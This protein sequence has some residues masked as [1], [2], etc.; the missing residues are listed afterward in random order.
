MPDSLAI[1]ST[2]RSLV[3][4]YEGA[5]RDI[6]TAFGLI[7]AAEE[8]LNAAFVMDGSGGL[9]VHDSQGYRGARF[10]RPDDALAFLKKDTWRLLVERLDIRRAL[11]VKAA[12]QLDE[13]LERGEM[14]DIT[15]EGVAAFLQGYMD[16]LPSLL[17]DAVKEVFELLRPRGAKYKTNA[18]FEIGARVIVSGPIE[19]GYSGSYRVRYHWRQDLLALEKVFRALDG[20]GEMAK[21]WASELEQAIEKSPIADGRGETEY[22]RFRACQNG[23]LHIEFKRPDLVASLNRIAGG[24]N[25]REGE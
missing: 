10:D 6:R 20:K 16:A 24:R 1:R 8:R 15:E 21:G 17:E 9:R 5:A 23:N 25:L 22:F 2:I 4:T 19:A 3:A 14:P 18:R 12:R 7:H 11:S 13:Q